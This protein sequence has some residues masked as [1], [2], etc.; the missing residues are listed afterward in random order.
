MS[1]AVK[2]KNKLKHSVISIERTKLSLYVNALDIAVAKQV[3]YM[4]TIIC[5]PNVSLES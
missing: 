3:L 2:G 4:F 1:I 5:L